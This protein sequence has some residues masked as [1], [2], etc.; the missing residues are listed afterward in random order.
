MQFAY[1]HLNLFQNPFSALDAAENGA[2]LVPQTDLDRIIERLQSPGYAIQFLG[3]RGR[4]KST[5]LNA[6]YRHFAGVPFSY[7]GKG[8]PYGGI[9][10]A[11]VVF[12]DEAQRIP[13]LKR[14]NVWSRNASFVIG[15]HWHHG[16]ELRRAGLAVETVILG[17]RISAESLQKM[18]QNRILAS[19]REVG[20]P[21]PQ[22][23]DAT[24]HSLTRRYRNNI[25]KM[26][27]ILY[28]KVETL[29]RIEEF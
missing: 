21:V 16:V 2:L 14:H 17:G 11:P 23:S 27:D 20:Q 25:R 12:I 24:A 9:P 5:H 4:G 7:L 29:E 28:D 10:T 6:L 15:S 1:A 18:S 3:R 13:W 22:L 26:F 8:E 19:V